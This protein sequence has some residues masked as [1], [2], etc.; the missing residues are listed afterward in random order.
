MEGQRPTFGIASAVCFGG[1][2]GKKARAARWGA[3]LLPT[4]CG[5]A[6]RLILAT[7]AFRTHRGHSY[8]AA[9]GPF[10]NGP[11]KR[12]ETYGL[13]LTALS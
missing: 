10:L 9:K 1:P 11:N 12:I 5:P 3:Q 13:V 2:H 7:C 4:Q 8:L 6:R